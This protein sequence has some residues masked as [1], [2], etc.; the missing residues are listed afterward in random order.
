MHF[1]TYL[2]A[3]KL[4]KLRKVNNTSNVYKAG[5]KLAKEPVVIKLPRF[6]VRYIDNRV[7]AGEFISRTDFIRYVLRRSID[8]DEER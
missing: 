7:S 8:E 5:I 6:M 2:T 4:L 1:L 3:G